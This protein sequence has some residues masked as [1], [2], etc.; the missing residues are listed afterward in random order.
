M[1]RVCCV[2]PQSVVLGA[3]LWSTMNDAHGWKV[4]FQFAFFAFGVYASRIN[5]A[6]IA[7]TMLMQN[8]RSRCFVLKIRPYIIGTSLL[9]T[10][11]NPMIC[12]L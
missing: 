9:G 2:V 3:I 8:L 12:Q 7:I 4:Y 1:A 11:S 10:F 5:T 6:L